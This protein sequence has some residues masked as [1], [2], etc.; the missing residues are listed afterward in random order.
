MSY[1]EPEHGEAV[2]GVLLVA[3]AEAS[4]VS[5]ATARC[6]S[7]PTEHPAGEGV[8]APCRIAAVLAQ[9]PACPRPCAALGA[10]DADIRRI[11]GAS[12]ACRSLNEHPRCW[13]ALAC[14]AAV[15]EP[16]P[17]SRDRHLSRFAEVR[18]PADVQPS[19]EAANVMLTIVSADPLAE[20][21]ITDDGV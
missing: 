12:G 13:P 14:T 4:E 15:N 20:R 16:T 11:I 2:C 18:Q 17:R 1:G 3:G 10:I 21:V 9:A 19:A 5:D 8:V 7:R 6:D